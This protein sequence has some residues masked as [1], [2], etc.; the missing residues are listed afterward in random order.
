MPDPEL[1]ATA[2]DRTDRWELAAAIFLSLATLLSAWSG[3]Q[4]SRWNGVKADENRSANVARMD[5]ER[6]WSTADRQLSIDVAVFATWLEAATR[7]DEALVAAVEARFRP[8]LQ[9]AFAAWLSGSGEG[10]DDLPP[11]S[12]FDQEEYRLAATDEAERL[13]ATAERH[14][15]EA[16]T[17]GQL[18]DN[19]VLTA[20][21]FAS[22][23]F[24]A[25]IAS[26]M[27]DPKVSHLAVGL[28]GTMFVVGTLVVLS[29]EPNVG[30]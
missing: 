28:S 19:Y 6:A 15:S 14:G 16:D 8:E 11:G 23:L 21:L 29:L 9:P 30:F 20:V 4:A 17:A 5:A 26:K 13:I 3:Y 24:F 25:G 27:S 10:G 12:P 18:A 2:D 22:V 1:D 7:D